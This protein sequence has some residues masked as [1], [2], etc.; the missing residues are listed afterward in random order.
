MKDQDPVQIRAK[1]LRI[2]IMWSKNG[3]GTLFIRSY[4]LQEK[5]P[6]LCS[7]PQHCRNPDY[8]NAS[9]MDADLL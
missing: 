8:R 3:S 9:F 1:Y 7:D 6:K 2:Q 4:S 5:Q